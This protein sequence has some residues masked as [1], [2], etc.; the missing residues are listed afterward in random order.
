MELSFSDDKN[1]F[2]QSP[3]EGT[4]NLLNSSTVCPEA[5]FWRAGN[6]MIGHFLDVGDTL[7]ESFPK[8]DLQG[9]CSLY[10]QMT[11][12]NKDCQAPRT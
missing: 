7:E 9:S 12:Y 6:G 3:K 5:G 10:S 8:V 1:V 4:A 2:V 11:Y